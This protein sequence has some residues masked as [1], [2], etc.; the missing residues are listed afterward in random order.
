MILAYRQHEIPKMTKSIKSITII[1]DAK[2]SLCCGCM[3]W[4]Q[5]HAVNKDMFKFITCQSPG[6]AEKFPDIKEEICLESMHVVLSD[7]KILKGDEALPEIVSRLQYY[8]ISGLLFKIPV[9]R[10][11]LFLIYRCIS[12]NRYI[13]SKTIWPLMKEE[14]LESHS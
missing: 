12:N 6:R 8:K 5:L 4:I 11:L 7:N 13:I 2:C 14:D 1:Y 3:K 10:S 9:I